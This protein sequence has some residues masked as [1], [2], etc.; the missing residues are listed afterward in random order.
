MDITDDLKLSESAIRTRRR[1]RRL[2]TLML[3][4]AL[5]TAT[6]GWPLFGTSILEAL[7][8]KEQSP[9]RAIIAYALLIVSSATLVLGFWYLLLAQVQRIARIVESEESLAAS[10]RARCHNCGWPC[11][12]PDR[13]CRHCGKNLAAALPTESQTARMAG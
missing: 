12:P 11:D 9:Y 8:I 4:I 2:A 10:E 1:S 3:I 6:A 7:R 13:F 5:L